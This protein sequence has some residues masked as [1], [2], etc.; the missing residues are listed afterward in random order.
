[1]L[2]GGD[3]LEELRLL[4]Y[5]RITHSI[6]QIVILKRLRVFAQMRKQNLHEAQLILRISI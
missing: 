3:G 1:M 6:L 2:L 4:S 5:L